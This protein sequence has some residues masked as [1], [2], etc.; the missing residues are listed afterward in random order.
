M[1]QHD[2]RNNVDQR[3]DIL[4]PYELALLLL[5]PD[6]Q[7]RRLRQGMLRVGRAVR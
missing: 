4:P 5:D 7:Q 1:R 6:A 2:T 3:I